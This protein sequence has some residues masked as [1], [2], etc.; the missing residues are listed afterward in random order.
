MLSLGK[1]IFQSGDHDQALKIF[2]TL[3]LHQSKISDNRDKV[4]MFYYMGQVRLHK[5]DAKRAKDMFARAL[6]IDANHAPSQQAM[7]DL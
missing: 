1:V 2:Q 6:R 3:M 7:A 4:D 5:G